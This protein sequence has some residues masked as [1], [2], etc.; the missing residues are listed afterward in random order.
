MHRV[1]EKKRQ[2]SNA[3]CRSERVKTPQSRFFVATSHEGINGLRICN[4]FAVLGVYGT[5]GGGGGEVR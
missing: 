3:N 1:W 4:L 5:G 2:K